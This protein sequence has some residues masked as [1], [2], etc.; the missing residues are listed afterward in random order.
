MHF[1]K[2]IVHKVHFIFLLAK[3]IKLILQKHKEAKLHKENMHVFL[4]EA[5]C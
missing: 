3:R 4:G 2:K 1:H 5:L